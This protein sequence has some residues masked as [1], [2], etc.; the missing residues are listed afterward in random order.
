MR[1]GVSRTQAQLRGLLLRLVTPCFFPNL[2]VLDS[3]NHGRRHP[4]KRKKEMFSGRRHHKKTKRAPL[5]RRCRWKILW[6]DLL[7]ILSLTHPRKKAALQRKKNWNTQ[8]MQTSTTWIDTSVRHWQRQRHYF[9]PGSGWV[10]VIIRF[11]LLVL[12]V[13]GYQ[14]F[15]WSSAILVW[16]SASLIVTSVAAS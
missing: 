7:P 11:F 5:Q 13:K 14:A 9:I 3:L 16:S 10:V 6:I 12:I 4:K 1:F 15:V 8:W 2:T